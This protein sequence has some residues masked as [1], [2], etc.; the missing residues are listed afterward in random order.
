MKKI[1][2]FVLAQMFIAGC[3]NTVIPV[4]TYYDIEEDNNII[5]DAAAD[6]GY[7]VNFFY[8]FN[9]K[10]QK[11]TIHID[12]IEKGSNRIFGSTS[13]IRRCKRS[14]WSESK[15]LVIT[16]ELA[17]TLGQVHTSKENNLMNDD[18]PV[19][20]Y[21]TYEEFEEDMDLELTGKQYDDMQQSLDILCACTLH[22]CDV[23]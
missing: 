7:G 11:G 23:K 16:H 21:P 20:S 2:F 15:R 6:L 3:G 13:S 19:D 5:E 22:K 10:S 14:F 18:F 1:L 4:H 12:I 8:G 17:H 9:S